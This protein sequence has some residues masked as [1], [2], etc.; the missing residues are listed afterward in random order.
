MTAFAL[1]Q[2]CRMIGVQPYRVQ[3]A[4]SIG[5]VPEPRLRISGRRVFEPID[6]KRLAKHFGVE[7]KVEQAAVA[8]V[9][10]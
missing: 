3:H 9:A 5:A 2:V 4:Y 7:M 8:E 10:E 6:I 1:Q